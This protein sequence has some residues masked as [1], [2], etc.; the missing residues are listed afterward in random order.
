[1]PILQ[2]DGW[3]AKRGK[4]LYVKTVAH[5]NPIKASHFEYSDIA[6][7]KLFAL[8]RWTSSE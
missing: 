1:M 4:A 5:T 6:L 7:P 2:N 8:I 3:D